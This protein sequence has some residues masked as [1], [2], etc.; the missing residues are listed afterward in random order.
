MAKNIFKADEFLK[1][2]A[3]G[4][5]S[6]PITREGVAKPDP[7][8]QQAFLFS[9]GG[10]CGPWSKVPAEVVESVE[11]LR[12][13]SCIDHEHPFVRLQL[14]EPPKE[15]AHATL[16]AA[17]ARRPIPSSAT[18]SV[19]QF[20]VGYDGATDCSA[21]FPA[22]TIPTCGTRF[23]T[24]PDLANATIQI[25]NEVAR[26]NAFALQLG[27]AALFTFSQGAC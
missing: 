16:F 7:T 4:S 8:D 20:C 18:L 22:A 21:L 6:E 3:D 11:F 23:I 14:K 25:S 5:L 15:N 2:L 19:F 10:S 27:V 13:V 12:M 24:A 17:L 9:E 26:L 1:A